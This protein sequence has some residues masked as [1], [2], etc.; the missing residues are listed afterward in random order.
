[1]DNEPIFE[2]SRILIDGSIIPS[3]TKAIDLTIHT[4]APA[5]WKLVDMETGQ[6]YV[7]SEEPNEYGKWIRIKDRVESRAGY[8]VGKWSDDDDWHP[9]IPFFGKSR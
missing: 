1:M 8:S 2:R 9:I 6:E 5:K 3:F 4:K 7:G